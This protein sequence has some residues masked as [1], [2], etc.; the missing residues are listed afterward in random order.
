MRERLQ[1]DLA[2]GL[3]AEVL[4]ELQALVAARPLDEG[5]RCA[6]MLALYR[7]GRQADALAAYRLGVGALRDELGLEPSAELRALELAILRQEV[8][9]VARSA[10]SA[11]AQDARRRVT[12]LFAQLAA[13]AQAAADAEAAPDPEAFLAAL[14]RVHDVT[15]S[16]C[17]AHGGTVVDL[18][19]DGLLAVFG[20]PV[21]HEDDALRA[22]RGAVEVRDRVAALRA[23]ALVQVGVATGDVVLHARRGGPAPVGEPVIVAE[24]LARDAA[25]DEVRLAAGTWELVRHAATGIALDGDAVVLGRVDAH[26]PPIDRWLDAPLVGRR[27]EL[28]HLDAALARVAASG[29][30]ELVTVLGEA[31]IGKTRLVAE[32]GRRGAPDA[33][34]LSGRC[35]SYG[36]GMTF[37]PLRQVVAQAA[38][39]RTSD[40]LAADLG[41]DPVIVQRLASAVGLEAGDAGDEIADAAAALLAALARDRPLAVIVDDAHWA[42]PA[43]L[44]LVLELRERLSDAPVLLVCVARAD[45]L[46]E[47]P[48]WPAGG[49]GA[50]TVRLGPLS[51]P[52]SE[53]LLQGL[54]AGG[55]SPTSDRAWPAP[56]AATPCSWS[57]SRPSCRSTRRRRPCRRRCS[58]CSPRAST[59]STRRSGW[60]WRAAPSRARRSAS[61]PSTPSPTGCRAP[62][63]RPPAAASSGATSWHRPTARGCA[64]GTR[65]SATPR[66]PR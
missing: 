32:L 56:P 20:H 47:R 65:S 10:A 28:A 24:A 19:N 11:V 18:R 53:A 7:S 21:A 51:P 62:T 39:G 37:W 63:W 23:G 16:A 5:L 44:E 46:D 9:D 42:E 6:L 59:A 48:G 12:C 1:A 34:V 25:V 31:G 38:N 60:C 45:L 52:D 43:L 61:P 27:A 2:C 50:S 54:P 29:R 15:A 64:S 26:A 40:G 30:A 58:R 4:D 35:P 13:D 36:E 8:P 55:P 49:D 14:E 17:A 41:V 57:S 66:T 22:V 33:R 3:H